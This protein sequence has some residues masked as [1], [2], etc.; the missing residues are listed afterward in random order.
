MHVLCQGFAG[1]PERCVDFLRDFHGEKRRCRSQEV[2]GS[3]PNTRG[4][5]ARGGLGGGQ[6]RPLGEE[7]RLSQARRGKVLEARLSGREA[8]LVV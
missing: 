8:F 3:R 5:G 6:R 1:C 4:R 7:V 2:P